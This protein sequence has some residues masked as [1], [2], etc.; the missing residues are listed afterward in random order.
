MVRSGNA[1]PGPRAAKYLLRQRGI[2]DPQ[3]ALRRVLTDLDVTRSRCSKALS[4]LAHRSNPEPLETIISSLV[5]RGVKNALAHQICGLDTDAAAA[6]ALRSFREARAL[7]RTHDAGDSSEA[8]A[9]PA[10]KAARREGMRM[11]RSHTQ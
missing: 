11:R 3:C 2:D 7:K 10:R 9:T 1:P 6:A 4:A 5:A 8:D